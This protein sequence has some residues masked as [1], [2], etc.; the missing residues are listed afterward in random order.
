MSGCL[1]E[2]LAPRAGAQNRK[3]IGKHRK[4]EKPQ[5]QGRLCLQIVEAPSMG[6]RRLSSGAG[7]S[8]VLRT[9]LFTSPFQLNTLR[10]SW[11]GRGRGGVCARA[12][13]WASVAH[14]NTRTHTMEEV[15][16]LLGGFSLVTKSCAQIQRQVCAH[17]CTKT[18]TR[19]YGRGGGWDSWRLT[20]PGQGQGAR[21]VSQLAPTWAAQTVVTE[22]RGL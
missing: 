5:K 17:L 11:G 2:L 15:P 8:L 22:S 9:I 20:G 4:G 14:T 12:C 7:H 10:E 13:A 18:H 3:T 1:K 16:I 6:E 21:P 19:F